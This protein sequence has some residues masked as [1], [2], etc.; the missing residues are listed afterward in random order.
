MTQ[1]SAESQEQLIRH[2]YRKAGLDFGLTRFVE[3][4]GTG[5]PVGD[6]IEMK[7]IGRVFR[8]YRSAQEPLYVGSL[9]SN[10]GHLEG[11]AGL[12]GVIKAI[13]TL[14][15]GIIP[16]NALFEQ[17]N[18]SIDAEFYNLSVPV[19]GIPWPSSG[20][21]R[22]SV[23]S[24]GFGG[25]NAHVVIDD[26][27]HYLQKRGLNGIHRTIPQVTSGF[28]D[29]DLQSLRNP[30]RETFDQGAHPKLSN[31]A[32]VRERSLITNGDSDMSNGQKICMGSDASVLPSVEESL[33]NHLLVW[34]APDEQSLGRLVQCYVPYYQQQI[35][36]VQSKIDQLAFTLSSRRSRMLWRTFAISDE[37][38]SLGSTLY[39]A[40]PSRA[41]SE[42]GGIA[43]V[44]TG[45]GAQYAAM[46]VELLQY[47]VFAR[48]LHQTNGVL[49]QLGC[50]W[51]IVEELRLGHNIDLPKY[52]QPICTALQI[53]LVELLRSFAI[54]PSMV[55]GHSS[56]EIAAAYTAHALSLASACKIAYYRGELAPRN[57]TVSGPEDAVDKLKEDLDRRGIF[58]VKLK[59]GVAYHSPPMRAI[60]S[61]YIDLIGELEDESLS[62]EPVDQGEPE[63]SMVSS[64]TGKPISPKILSTAQYWADNLV[65]PV[66]FSHAIHHLSHEFRRLGSS[67]ITDIIEVGPHATLRRPIDDTLASDGQQGQIRYINTLHKALPAHHSILKLVGTLF[68]NGHPVS[69]ESANQLNVKDGGTPP[70]FLVDC[71]EYPF[72]HSTKYLAE[73]RMS[74]DYRLREHVPREVLGA[75]AFDWNPLEPRW[76]KFLNLQ[77]VPWANEHIVT[78]TTLYPGAGMLLMAIEAAKQMCPEERLVAGYLIKEARFLNP[79]VVGP[80]WEET[81]EVVIRLL[82]L[83]KPYEKES[84]W[85]DIRISTLN[86]GRWSQTFTAIIETQY[87]P[88]QQ[89]QVDNGRER[90]L[91]DEMVLRV[92]Q[93]QTDTCRKSIDRKGLYEAFDACGIV[94]GGAFRVLDDVMYDGA[95]N[96]MAR[97]DVSN[98]KHTTASVFHPAVLDSAFQLLSVQQSH[99]LSKRTT[100]YVPSTV[101]DVWI[102]SAGWQSP[103]TSSVHFASATAETDDK[104]FEGKIY[105]VNDQD[106]VLCVVSKLTMAP[107]SGGSADWEEARETQLLYGLAWKPLL[108]MLDS[109]SLDRTCNVAMFSRNAAA[110]SE[111]RQLL[112]PTLDRCIRKT[113]K[114]LTVKDRQRTPSFLRRQIEWI[115]HHAATTSPL[116]TV[117]ASDVDDEVCLKRLESMYPA[118][119]IFPAIARSLKQILAGERDPLQVGFETGLAEA[120]YSDVFASLCD[121][122]FEKL[123]DLMCHEQPT[124][125]VL[126]VG[127][128]TGGMTGYVLAALAEA[129]KRNGG[130]RFSDYTY[131]DISPSFFENARNRFTEHGS[132]IIFK[133]LDLEE[134]VQRQGFELGAYD[135]VI[136]GSVLHATASLAR[137]LA[138]IRSLL[139][140]GGHLLFLE[141]TVPAQAATNFVFGNFPGWWCCK[142]EWRQWS[143]AIDEDQWNQ[144]LIDNGFSGNRVVLRDYQSTVCHCCSIILSTRSGTNNQPSSDSGTLG[145]LVI[146]TPNRNDNHLMK[147]AEALSKLLGRWS[148]K[149][150]PLGQFEDTNLL[151]QDIIISLLEANTPFLIG[152]KKEE[153]QSLQI[154]IGR[155]R[156]LMWITGA[157]EENS[158]DP[159]MSLSKGFLRAMR[160]EHIDKHIVTLAIEPDVNE[161]APDWCVTSVA[162]LAVKAFKASFE[163]ASPE[164]EYIVR[165]RDIGA[166]RITEKT[167]MNG[168]MRSLVAPLL[169]S[170]SWKPGPPLKLTVGSPGF[171]DSLEFVKDP[172]YR[173]DLLP[174]EIEVDAKA[175]GLSFRDV[176]VALGRLPGDDLGYD[177]SGVVSRV[178]ADC[179]LSIKPGDR[180]C[181]S[182]LSA[183]RMFPRAR[184]GMVVKVPDQ[185]SLEAAASFISPGVTAFYSL[186]DVARL[187]KGEKV[188][189]HSGCGSTGQMA[190]WVAK[191][192]GA[193]VFTTVGFD[194]KKELLVKD[195]DIAPDHIFY[196]RDTSFAQG[197]MRV[198]DG[199]GVDVVLNSLAGDG[200]RASFE[201][202]APYGRFV[203]I[204]K[205][206]ITSNSALPMANFARNVSFSA[207]DLYHVAQSNPRMA[208]ELLSRVMSF[209]SAGKILAPMPLHIYPASE[210]EKAFRYLQS[211]TN[212]G[213]IIIKDSS[214]SL[215]QTATYIVAGGLGGLGRAIAMWMARKGAKHL[216]LLSRSGPK[217]PAAA[218]TVA[219]LQEQGVQVVTPLCD[220]SSSDELHSVLLECMQKMPPVKGC[221]NSAMVLQ[222]AVFENMTQA[223]WE[224][225]IRSK[226]YTSWNLHELVPN[227]ERLDFF[228]LLSSLSGIYGNIAQSNYASGCSFQ[229]ALAHFRTARGQKAVSL[230]IGWM[231]N[232]GVIAENAAYRQQRKNT[233]DM[234]QI[235]DS[236]LLAL[237]DLHC[238]P[239]RPV[240]KH[241]DSQLLVGVVTP[242]DLR[243]QGQ[244]P[245]A[246]SMVPVF[247]GFTQLQRSQEYLSTDGS[248]VDFAALFR[249]ATDDQDRAA[250]VV[251]A[252]SSKLARALSVSIEDIERNKQL[253]DYGVDS[254]M[255]VELRNWIARDFGANVAV[256]DIMGG[257]KI[258]AIGEMVN[259]RSQHSK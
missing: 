171:L 253:H 20:Q 150:L 16:P 97:V 193:E 111:F 256:F 155:A 98:G 187:K 192:V 11:S 188:L 80:T 240:M 54:S 1:P 232:I 62:L 224:M 244:T 64:V 141:T 25:T 222:D 176:F 56:G 243:A 165:G 154:L 129:E 131:T 37:D 217:S 177:Y 61:K 99:G 208:Y 219:D 107:V 196:S 137:T 242:R 146:V 117:E 100:A 183:M 257:T 21:R 93:R 114:S 166:L 81:S 213:R 195:F 18:P 75:R 119:G 51:D 238:D 160:S 151:D 5:T 139:K 55:I 30:Q 7:A 259:E 138:N 103:Q 9:K 106:S 79:M 212:T 140:P 68:C 200:L 148:C 229:D 198:T 35:A 189:I 17:M 8:T 116:E 169:Q 90:K 225:S 153:F 60:A 158:D 24:Y 215:D 254:L 178:G 130:T 181:G 182:T 34:S 218:G 133:T 57:T 246:L 204:G 124:M 118:W 63:I 157:G 43:F 228:V 152:V 87:E 28:S 185:L 235:E 220:A 82:P 245:P 210:A 50:T 31:G 191:M 170:E 250:I 38:E 74:R 110:I 65:S 173:E 134:E 121:H 33:N 101:S 184:S 89:T 216:I 149:V 236:E 186:I 85:S 249:Q 159:R 4:H 84:V 175:W 46:G 10:T 59:T 115:D 112:D 102:S 73:S 145:R 239:N 76:R 161:E 2:V 71:P 223:Q 70:P 179:D 94:Y 194:D 53:A 172:A 162:K 22:I 96:A 26:A 69:L 120:F 92:F 142:E 29:Y 214:W 248:I 123:M 241:E 252:L 247:S 19:K 66:T 83:Q 52:S 39:T 23:S 136:A 32:F 36:G 125:R 127:A 144:V 27:Y 109:K 77:S 126:E 147:L 122:R 209:I 143:P 164:V 211:G 167:H 58:N 49:R 174:D 42:I 156:R 226:V 105:I 203:E 234:N 201:C 128:G 113:A 135:V 88:T 108:S 44:F 205:A 231:R 95:D 13:Y 67:P 230:D 47:P 163:E 72:D 197:V 41:S 237:L 258:A 207:V 199:Y 251:R 6:P 86:Q 132:R 180:V 40:K 104:S 206:D 3:A 190:I 78:G 15:R 48:T 221:I 202:V 12:A 168:E 255:A 45:Q 91:R 227:T 14:E 233:A